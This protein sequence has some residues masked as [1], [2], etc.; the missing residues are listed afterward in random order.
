ML[1]EAQ[2]D[3]GDVVGGDLRG[4][5]SRPLEEVSD[6]LGG[7]V[8]VHAGEDPGQGVL[9]EPAVRVA[10]LAEAV[11]EEDDA[12]AGPERHRLGR[13]RRE[14]CLEVDADRRGGQEEG[15]LDVR[16]AHDER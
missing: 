13:V 11:G 6:D 1:L 8:V 14:R 4:E 2:A 10:Q 15:A 3:D 7:G 5:L 9:E 12:V 16:R